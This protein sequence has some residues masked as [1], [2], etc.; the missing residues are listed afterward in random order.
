MAKNTAARRLDVVEG[1]R[2]ASLRTQATICYCIERPS[3]SLG[4]MARMSPFDQVSRRTLENWSR[5]DGW[6]DRRQQAQ[7]ELIER[8]KLRVGDT[9]IDEKI[10]QLRSLERLSDEVREYLES[11]RLKARSYESLVNAYVKLMELIFEQREKLLS[12]LSPTQRSEYYPPIS[13]ELSEAEKK[14]AVEAIKEHRRKRAKESESST[15]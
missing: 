1:E 14:D 13:V 3:I 9:L 15:L 2:P 10:Q 5:A 4:K 12:D 8:A 7:D 11:D 6:V